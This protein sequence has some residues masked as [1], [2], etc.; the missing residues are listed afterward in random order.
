MGWDGTKQV[1]MPFMSSI[2]KAFV[3]LAKEAEDCH[4]QYKNIKF[5]LESILV[6]SIA[7]IIYHDIMIYLRLG[8]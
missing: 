2:I 4:G 8:N 1:R 5:Y 3:S 6:I 7:I